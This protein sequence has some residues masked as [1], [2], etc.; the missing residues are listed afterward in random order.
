MSS[1][2]EIHEKFFPPTRPIV[3]AIRRGPQVRT[4]S[5]AAVGRFAWVAEYDTGNAAI[6]RRRK[7][8]YAD[9]CELFDLTDDA[10][11]GRGRGRHIIQARRYVARRMRRECGYSL[12]QI[13]RR[14]GGR[15]HTTVMNLLRP[16]GERDG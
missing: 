16:R 3:K 1:A 7:E 4:L 5:C 14:M 8:I 9:A 15:D 12:P 13:G 10:L 6:E 2:R 11:N